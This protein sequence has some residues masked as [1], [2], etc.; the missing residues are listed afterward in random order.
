MKRTDLINMAGIAIAI[1]AGVLYI[2]ELKG[3]VDE[4]KSRVDA[5]NPDAINEAVENA[6]SRLEALTRNPTLDE[7]EFHIWAD[8]NKSPEKEMI[9]QDEGF[10][11]LTKVTGDFE[12]GGEDV[13][14]VIKGGSW[15]LVVKSGQQNGIG[16]SARCWKWPLRAP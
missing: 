5:L 3:R 10:C 11:Y 15:Y 12:G 16:A 4:L 6:I 13:R 9:G 14:I 8:K 7:R 2:G 1:I